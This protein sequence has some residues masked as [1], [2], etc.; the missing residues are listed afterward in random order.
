M[1]VWIEYTNRR[2][3][4]SI[5]G[6]G[7]AYQQ[8]ESK[9]YKNKNWRRKKGSKIQKLYIV[10]IFEGSSPLRCVCV[11]LKPLS[12]FSK[13][14]LSACLATQL[15]LQDLPLSTLTVRWGTTGPCKVSI[16]APLH[17]GS[18][19][20]GQQGFLHFS[21]KSASLSKKPSC[22][23]LKLKNDKMMIK[24]VR[25]DAA[26]CAPPTNYVQGRWWIIIDYMILTMH[27]V[28]YDVYVYVVCVCMCVCAC[29]CCTFFRERG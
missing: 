26:I 27:I 10:I 6:D 25:N 7:I 14:L 13:E 23:T 20:N 28:A 12:L 3:Y 11:C 17:H 29:I 22:V 2:S 24:C 9:K 19:A 4:K 5:N 1:N 21:A 8:Q 18:T 16:A 15:A